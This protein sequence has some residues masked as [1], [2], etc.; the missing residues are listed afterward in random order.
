LKDFFVCSSVW[1][2]CRANKTTSHRLLSNFL[3]FFY[4]F[5]A[6][7]LGPFPPTSLLLQGRWN[8]K[9]R[10]SLPLA[11]RFQHFP[12]MILDPLFPTLSPK[13]RRYFFRRLHPPLPPP[14]I[15]SRSPHF[16]PAFPVS[17]KQARFWARKC[18]LKPFSP[19]FMVFA[20]FEN[21]FFG[22]AIAALGNEIKNLPSF[23]IRVF[24]SPSLP[25][26]F[27]PF[28]LELQSFEVG[29][30]FY[31]LLDFVVRF[32]FLVLFHGFF[33]PVT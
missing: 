31:R 28:C 19:P 14:S 7:P 5:L 18:R 33:P 30:L 32:L 4:R 15:F 29:V 6:L 24:R 11:F 13:L 16:S 8:Q 23:S 25:A 27:E 22:A 9:S 17:T 10:V 21:F 2:F 3:R 20:Y 26:I 1:S 12:P